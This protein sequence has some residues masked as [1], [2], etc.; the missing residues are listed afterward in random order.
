MNYK[1]KAERYENTLNEIRDL[2]TNLTKMG[3]RTKPHDDCILHMIQC[4]F[5]PEYEKQVKEDSENLARILGKV[6]DISAAPNL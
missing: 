4:A 6:D 2:I 5:D 1:E 3:M